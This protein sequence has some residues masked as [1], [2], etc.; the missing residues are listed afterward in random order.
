MRILGPGMA[1][2]QLA[3]GAENAITFELGNENGRVN[4]RKTRWEWSGRHN[5]NECGKSEG[6]TS[7]ILSVGSGMVAVMGLEG[8]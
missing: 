6:R 2:C 1:T 3:R 4:Q 5:K 8:K 7:K